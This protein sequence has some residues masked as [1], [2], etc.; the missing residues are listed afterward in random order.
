MECHSLP[1]RH[2]SR[3]AQN[4]QRPSIS[5]ISPIFTKTILRVLTL[6]L[7]MVYHFILITTLPT[8]S[9]TAGCSRQF[10]NTLDTC[11]KDITMQ[12]KIDRKLQQTVQKCLSVLTEQKYFYWCLYV[13]CTS[14]QVYLLNSC[15]VT[16]LTSL[17]K[18]SCRF[19]KPAINTN[20]NL[21][22]FIA[23][24]TNK[25][26]KKVGAKC[27]QKLNDSQDLQFILCIAFHYVL[28]R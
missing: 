14:T 2:F 24:Q 12:S 13:E 11:K 6:P 16:Y 25:P 15:F 17:V 7:L 28:H 3:S 10:L 21:G 19:K 23:F 20:N 5:T 22:S 27:V 9:I 26:T 8:H 4:H 1:N 18:I